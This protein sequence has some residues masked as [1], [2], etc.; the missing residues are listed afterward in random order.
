MAMASTVPSASATRMASRSVAARKRRV[1]LAVGVVFSDIF[2]NQREV[3]RRDFA[4]DAGFGALAAAHSLEGVGSGKMSDVQARFA[5]LLR[6][7]DVA[8]DDGGFGSRR[9]GAQAETKA[10]GASVH[11]AVFGQARVFRVLHDG[12]IQLRTETQSHAHDV[13]VEDGLAVVGDGDGSGA[14]KCREVGERATFAAAGGGGDG[15]DIDHG[16]ALGIPQP[17]DP[18]R[19]VDHRRGVGHGADGGETSGGGGGGAGGDGFFVALSGLAQVDVQIDE[20]G[21]DDQA[22][23]IEF[24]VG[25]AADFVGQSD[26]GDAAIAQKDVHGRVDLRRRID[27]VAAFDQKA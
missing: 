20:A 2:V 27:Q 25:A 23:G 19:R 9:H 14:L 22:A 16:S 13:I 10:G 18:F 17:S 3:V 24:L 7:R 5:N 4:G 26:L 1:H 21:S 11:R 6:E 8:V 15:K 12:K